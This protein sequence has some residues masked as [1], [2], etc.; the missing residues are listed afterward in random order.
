M[1]RPG[2]NVIMLVA[3]ALGVVAGSRIF[4]MVTGG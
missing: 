2:V 4:A 1:R 3:I